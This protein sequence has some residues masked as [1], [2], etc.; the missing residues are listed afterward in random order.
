MHDDVG[1][2]A[3]TDPAAVDYTKHVFVRHETM[4]RVEIQ[5]YLGI[6]YEYAESVAK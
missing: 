5:G 4:R 3:V 6:R 2:T 1:V